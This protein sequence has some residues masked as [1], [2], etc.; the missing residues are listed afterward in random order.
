MVVID[1]VYVKNGVMGWIYG[2]KCNGWCMFNKKFVKN[3]ELW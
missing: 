1:S 3:V 2:W